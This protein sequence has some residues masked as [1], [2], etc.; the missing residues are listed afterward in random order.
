[1][2]S[3]PAAPNMAV[4]S[5]ESFSGEFVSRTSAPKGISA[6]HGMGIALVERKMWDYISDLLPD[7]NPCLVQ[8]MGRDRT[9]KGNWQK[10]A[11][12]VHNINQ[13]H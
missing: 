1:M 2:E 3:V 13:F 4:S 5:A 6:S 11:L 9:G 10:N 12:E 8:L 7:D